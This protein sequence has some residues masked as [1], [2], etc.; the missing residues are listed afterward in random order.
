MKAKHALFL[1]AIGF[2]LE[3]LGSWIRIMHWAKSDYWTIAG[4]LL[5][6]AGVVLLAYKI[7]TYPGWKNFWNR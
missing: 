3:F 5:K 4:I 7:V 1:L 2:V 6:I